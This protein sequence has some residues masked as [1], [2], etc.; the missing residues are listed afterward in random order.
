MTHGNSRDKS[1]KSR[2]PIGASYDAG[3]NRLFMIKA[4]CFMGIAPKH[5]LHFPANQRS[6]IVSI[7]EFSFSNRHSHTSNMKTNPCPRPIRTTVAHT[8]VLLALCMTAPQ[9]VGCL[10]IPRRTRFD[11]A[12]KTRPD[13][14]QGPTLP[15]RPWARP[16][17]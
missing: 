16:S 6:R 11:R 4:Q 7:Q 9:G 14:P 13:A 5:A 17:V 1:R 3:R 12:R 10:R 2:A 15:V 8:I